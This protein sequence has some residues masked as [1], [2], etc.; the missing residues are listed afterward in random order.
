MIGWDSE[1]ALKRR[2]LTGIQM[3][4]GKLS[5]VSRRLPA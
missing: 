3:Q 2:T 1:F 4:G 5:M